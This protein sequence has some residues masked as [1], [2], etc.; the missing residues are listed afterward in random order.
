[1]VT[2]V[3][4]SFVRALLLAGVLAAAVPLTSLAAD[5]GASAASTTGPRAVGRP[6][7]VVHDGVP[8]TNLSMAD[9]REL[10]L[11]RR[12]FWPGGTRV[13]LI[14]EARAGV[15]RRT[16]VETLGKMSDLQFQQYWIGQVFSQRATRAPRA[17][18]DRRLALALVSAIPGALA[19]VEAGAIPP[20]TRVL[21]ID[22]RHPDDDGYPL[23]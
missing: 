17:A 12:R 1:M 3:T 4:R 8:L 9:L 15:G 5:P 11:G 16:F 13:E 7:V 23:K 22:G 6:V 20:R 14:V 21:E 10:A 19:V 18:P 2:C